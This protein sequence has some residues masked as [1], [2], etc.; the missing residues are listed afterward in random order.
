M[1][2]QSGLLFTGEFVSARLLKSLVEQPESQ[3]VCLS[4]AFVYQ[5]R[6]ATMK[7]FHSN[8]L[9]WFFFSKV[10]FLFKGSPTLLTS[11]FFFSREDR[12]M[13]LFPHLWIQPA[14]LLSCTFT[15]LRPADQMVGRGK[16]L[17]GCQD[18][19]G[20]SAELVDKLL[21]GN[22]AELSR[23]QSWRPAAGL[24]KDAGLLVGKG[25]VSAMAAISPTPCCAG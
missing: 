19:W 6:E 9:D 21:A 10:D 17:V 15:W 23:P 13:I 3:M 1:K 14:C 4:F 22:R 20:I 12:Y 11:Y 7:E 16:R 24:F 5:H 25:G 8:L 2:R 18:T